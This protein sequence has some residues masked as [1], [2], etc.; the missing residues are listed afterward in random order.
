MASFGAY[1]FYPGE[2]FTGV[3]IEQGPMAVTGYFQKQA[4]VRS[5]DPPVTAP[6]TVASGGTVA[7]PTGLDCLVYLTMP[8]PGTITAVKVLSSTLSSATSYSPGGTIA[9]GALAPPV[10]VKGPG[11]IAVTYSGTLSWLWQ[12]L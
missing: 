12:P 5:W 11:A 7:N 8:A 1:P 3:R 6:G 9:G 4:G 2:S 10:I